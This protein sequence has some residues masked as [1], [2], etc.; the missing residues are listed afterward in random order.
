LSDYAA[1]YSDFKRG[2]L[3]VVALSPESQRKSRRLR[4][5][6]KL[7]FPVLADTHFEAARALGLMDHEKPGL[8]T[9]ATLILDDRHHILLSSLNDW[10]RS[11][12][13]RDVLEYGRSLRQGDL[14][15]PRPSELEK[16]KPGRFFLRGL[17]NMALGVING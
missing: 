1:L 10:A 8:P 11:L 9:P 6:L 17:A 14:T 5:G 16:P 15:V 12:A 3:E 2:G 4:K 7:P 13:A